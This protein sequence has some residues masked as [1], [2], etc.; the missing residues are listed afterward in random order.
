M[1]LQIVR[2]VAVGGHVEDFGHHMPIVFT[3]GEKDGVAEWE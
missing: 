2:S 1:M 3:L